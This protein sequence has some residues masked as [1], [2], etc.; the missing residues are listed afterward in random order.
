M[1]TYPLTNISNTNLTNRV[2]DSIPI[3]SPSCTNCSIS[4]L[5]FMHPFCFIFYFFDIWL[6]STF[7]LSFIVLLK[8][9]LIV[10][11]YIHTHPCAH[12]RWAYIP[13]S[14]IIGHRIW[15]SSASIDPLIFWSV[16]NNLCSSQR[17]M[18]VPVIQKSLTK[19]ENVSLL[20]N[21]LILT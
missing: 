2:T 9:P 1:L 14:D 17:R 12:L 21:L 7:W 18:R 20:N 8:T 4:I 13:R 19:F 15:K 6:L 5:Q 16:W 10:F 11:W 3:E